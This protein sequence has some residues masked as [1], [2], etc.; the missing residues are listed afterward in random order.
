MVEKTKHGGQNWLL[1]NGWNMDK[2]NDNDRPS[3]YYFADN[4]RRRVPFDCFYYGYDF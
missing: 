3:Y 4:W 2:E 1:Q